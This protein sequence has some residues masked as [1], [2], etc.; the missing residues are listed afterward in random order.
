MSTDV[1]AT[2]LREL[3]EKNELTFAKLAKILGK[4]PQVYQNYEAG[5]HMPSQEMVIKLARFYGVPTDYLLGSDIPTRKFRLQR[6]A[7]AFPPHS[8]ERAGF[9]TETA[10]KEVGWAGVKFDIRALPDYLEGKISDGDL[11]ERTQE[12]ITLLVEKARITNVL[13]K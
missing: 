4:T 1:T 6:E 5:R 13:I 7:D 12:E 2:R 8:N 9:I 3:R 11:F 10:S